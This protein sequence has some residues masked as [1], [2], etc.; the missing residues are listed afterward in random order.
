MGVLDPNISGG[1]AWVFETPEYQV[2]GCGCLRPQYIWWR[3][4]GGG[5]PNTS[6]RGAWVAETPKYLVERR[7]WLR[8][9]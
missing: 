6:G 2:D 9:Q 3:G 7:G 1:G 4:I 5:D 8:L